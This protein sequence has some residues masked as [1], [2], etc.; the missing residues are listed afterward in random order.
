MSVTRASTWRYTDGARTAG[1]TSRST[2]RTTCLM[3]AKRVRHWLACR[4]LGHGCY[5]GAHLQRRGR[6]VISHNGGGGGGANATSANAGDAALS[7]AWT[8]QA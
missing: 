1:P 8:G 6:P 3:V 2:F 7:D 4:Q 5:A